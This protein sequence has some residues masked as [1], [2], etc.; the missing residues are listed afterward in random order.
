MNTLT[1]HEANSGREVVFYRTQVF[2][3]RH[4]PEHRSTIIVSTGGAFC[5]VKESVDEVKRLLNAALAATTS[6]EETT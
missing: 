2:Y 4:S 5:P 1:L 3:A 6:Q